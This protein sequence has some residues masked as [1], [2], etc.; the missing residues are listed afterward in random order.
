MLR[1]LSLRPLR[2]RKGIDRENAKERRRE[3]GNRLGRVFDKLS[4]EVVAAAIE[5]H[6]RLGPGFL[7][8]V[9][10]RALRVELENRGIS[11]ESQKEIRVIYCGQLVGTHVLDLLVEDTIVVE[12]K[13]I[14]RL[15][16]IHY[17]QV[18]SYLCATGKTLGLLMN[19]SSSTLVVK[20]IVRN[21]QDE[22]S[23]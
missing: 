21:Y 18:R 5:V 6:R 23:A 20:R 1:S 9:Y 19:F 3:K 11:F 13:A 12:L 16:G 7:E 22:E 2:S 8:S 14:E 10:D 15:D 4:G 17:A